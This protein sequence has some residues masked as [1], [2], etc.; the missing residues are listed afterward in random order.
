MS[1]ILTDSNSRMARTP[2]A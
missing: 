1:V 2:V